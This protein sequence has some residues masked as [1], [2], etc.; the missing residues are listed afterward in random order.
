M[1]TAPRHAK[2]NDNKI[3]SI[4]IWILLPIFFTILAIFITSKKVN[5]VCAPITPIYG[6]ITGIKVT[7][8][9]SG[10]YRVWSRMSAPDGQNNSF[11]L[12]I[13]NNVCAQVVGDNS[14]LGS[15]LKWINYKSGITNSFMDFALPAGTYDLKIIGRE[16]GVKLDRILFLS[17]LTCNPNTTDCENT[18]PADTTPPSVNL[19]APTN[20]QTVSGNAVI[21]SA[22][23]QDNVA[24]TKVEFYVD[25]VLVNSDTSSPFNYAWNSNSV[26]E[27]SHSI[28]AKAYDA[29]GLSTNSASVI[30]VVD[31]IPDAKPTINITAPQANTTVSGTVQIQA[32]ATDDVGITKVEFYIDGVFVGSDSTIPYSFSWLSTT[33]SE[34]QN[35]SLT[36]K[37]FDTIQQTTTSSAVSVRVDNVDN[38]KPS[39]TISSPLDGIT[40]SGTVNINASAMDNVGIVSIRVLVDGIQKQIQTSSPISYVWQ[41][42]DANNGSHIIRVEASDAAGNIESAISNVIIQNSDVTA[43]NV[44]TGATAIGVDGAID[45]RWD[46]NSETDLS[47]YSVRLK[48]VTDPDN[49]WV[50]PATNLLVTQYK[51][52]GLTNGVAYNIE[53]RAID[54][55]GNRSDYASATSTPTAPP[56]TTP[57][58]APTNFTAS[59]VLPTQVN[60]AWSASTSMDTMAYNIYRNGSFVA[61]VNSTS[62]SFGQTGLTPSTTY[63]Y[64]LEAVDSSENE[65]VQNSVT[66]ST[67]ALSNKG[68]VTGVLKGDDG[69]LLEGYIFTYYGKTKLSTRSSDRNGIYYF[70]DLPVADYTITAQRRGYVRGSV[71]VTIIGGQTVIA[72][73]IL[74]R[75]R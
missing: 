68:N 72:P 28:F 43:P 45:F 65:S 16:P 49:T 18:T 63:I 53:V 24:V 17:D 2:F 44:P 48:K 12:E 5:A 71:D 15:S 50:W 67:P 37:A 38:I 8:A 21:I 74:V 33:A 61:K 42:T 34:D 19:T 59:A 51:F 47:H 60:L 55:S 57:P 69:K 56:D 52:T 36:A 3:I 6:E 4:I 75:K 30:V 23:A 22:T 35:H 40:T 39:V 64:S 14:E 10:T 70:F 54:T 13:G 26:A 31:N 62:T 11:Y 25:N 29:A 41:T 46:A 20:T 73:D 7:I 9:T 32:N 58:N 66:V 1:I 27:G